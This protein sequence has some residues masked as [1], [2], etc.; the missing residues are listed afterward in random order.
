MSSITDLQTALEI[1]Q[2]M[3]ITSFG[4]LAIIIHQ[5]L[6]GYGVDADAVFFK[7]N[8]S[9][10]NLNAPETRLS[11]EELSKLISISIE[12][13][14]DDA[15]IIETA[16]YI[17]PT[18][19]NALGVAL[20]SSRTIRKFT[21]RL[22]EYFSFLTTRE[23]VSLKENDECSSLIFSDQ[24]INADRQGETKINQILL[25]GTMIW[26]HRML[27]LMAGPNFK[28]THVNYGPNNFNKKL[29]SSLTQH[30]DCPVF[31]DQEENSLNINI[32]DMDK[33]LPSANAALAQHG[34]RIMLDILSRMKKTDYPTRT[35]LKLLEALS[36]GDFSKVTI[37]RSLGLSV[38]SFHNKLDEAGTSYQELLDETRLKLSKQY[39][40]QVNYSV[41]D[42]A[43]LLGFSDFSNFSRAFKKWTGVTPSEYREKY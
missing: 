25:L 21:D 8:V 4:G 41:G 5:T 10:K 7:A 24:K 37:A 36:S 40:R 23:N 19:F 31:F 35:R 28:L 29:K 14:K 15:F 13:T 17:Q 26:I 12:E 38:R 33:T 6:S 2:D 3:P 43:F 1:E 27:S 9:L 11:F 22:I 16:K 39:L 32:E 20:F 34:D 42:I 18:F 30:F